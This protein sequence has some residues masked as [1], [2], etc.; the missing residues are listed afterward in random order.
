MVP[1]DADTEDILELT[2]IIRKGDLADAS[3][4]D[5]DDDISFE[6]ELEELFA[7]DKGDGSDAPV[8]DG[9]DLDLD[10]LEKELDSLGSGP[11]AGPQ[12]APGKGG[13]A[14][15]SGLDDLDDLESALSSLGGDDLPDADE[16]GLDEEEDDDIDLSSL[17]DL[18]NE[19]DGSAKP[20]PQPAAK[21]P[22]KATPAPDPDDSLDGLGDLGSLD[23]LDDLD[24][25]IAGLDGLDLDDEAP[26]F[27]PDP[28]PE[29]EPEPE[30]AP[31][32]APA[33][34]PA[35]PAHNAQAEPVPASGRFMEGPPAVLPQ[36]ALEG[37][38]ERTD[39]LEALVDK[40]LTSRLEVRFQELEQRLAAAPAGLVQELPAGLRAGLE[41]EIKAELAPELIRD[42]KAAL[43]AEL[44]QEI[45]DALRAE[46]EPEMERQAAAAAARVIREEITALL[47]GQDA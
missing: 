38:L 20:A 11:G 29:P 35:A 28:E 18:L 27:G 22:Q 17:D 16:P 13:G 36:E 32:P 6:Q 31:K 40:E 47:K 21:A 4:G 2:E 1:G 23:G 44:T 42:I 30:P 12:A 15:L 43:A 41:A 39:R 8:S 9:D 45:R 26:A 25:A 10:D 34:R 37:L 5:A 7:N 3:G 19:L 14:T 24:K 33:P 46:L